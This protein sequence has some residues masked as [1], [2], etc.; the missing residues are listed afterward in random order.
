MVVIHG[1][2][3]HLVVLGV[4]VAATLAIYKLV[5]TAPASMRAS[6]PPALLAGVGIGLLT[7]LFG[8]L[9]PLLVGGLA[10]LG[11]IATAFAVLIWL[12][13]SFQILLYGAAWA[14]LRRDLEAEKRSI[15][16]I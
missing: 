16:E 6:L 1:A 8:V 12:N 10:G 2:V 7:N 4:F 14:R 13:F 11:V 9:A 3:L 5:P 15:V